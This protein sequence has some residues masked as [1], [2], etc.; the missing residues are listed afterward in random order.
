M[1]TNLIARNE[2]LVAHLPNLV[3]NRKAGGRYDA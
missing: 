1:K 2:H 3:I